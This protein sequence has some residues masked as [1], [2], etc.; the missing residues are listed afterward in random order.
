MHAV[1]FNVDMKE[2]WVGDTDA[3]LDQLVAMLQSVPEFIQGTWTTDGQRG[4]SLLLFE[5]ES[6]AREVADNA[7]LPRDAS[8]T[9]RSA[10]VYTV[11]RNVG[12]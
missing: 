12:A 8:A 4:V 7:A 6:V 9:L 11:L 5:S 1:V 2:G 3:E 10:D